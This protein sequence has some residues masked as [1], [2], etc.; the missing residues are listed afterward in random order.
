MN[1]VICLISTNFSFSFIFLFRFKIFLPEFSFS[2]KEYF[3]VTFFPIDS[4]SALI[5]KIPFTSISKFIF[6]VTLPAFPLGKLSILN[7]FNLSKFLKLLILT[8]L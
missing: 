1:S 5:I 6:S 8:F 3:S 7:S 4:T 2:Y